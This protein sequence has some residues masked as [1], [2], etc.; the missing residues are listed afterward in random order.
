MWT[1][2]F[3]I[4]LT[5][6]SAQQPRPGPGQGQQGQQGQGQQQQQFNSPC[7]ASFD[8]VFRK[9]FIDSGNFQLDIIFSLI[10]NGTSGPLPQGTT[11]A[12]LLP[13]LCSIRTNVETCVNPLP[14]GIAQRQQCTDREQLMMNS[15]IQ[16]TSRAVASLCGVEPEMPACLGKFDARFKACMGQN[17]VNDDYFF[18]LLGNT[19]EGLQMTYDQLKNMTCVLQT[20]KTIVNCASTSLQ[21]LN[22]ECTQQEQY[23]VGQTLQNMMA[24]YQ[25]VCSG[26]PLMPRPPPPPECLMKFENDL[27][28][29]SRDS[30]TLGM[31][32][33]MM[34]LTQGTVPAGKDPNQM[35]GTICKNH[36][37]FEVCGKNA[38]KATTC[39][40]RNLLIAEGTFANIFITIGAYCHD[41]SMPGACMLTLQSQFAKCFG[42]V[43][44]DEASYVGNVTAHK[45]A[46][47][48]ST[49]QAAQTYC[50]KRKE[51]YVC[52]KKV[53]HRCPGAEQT[54][55]LTG[56]DLA[57]ME[58]AVNVL[59]SD[60]DE[61]LIGLK[62]FAKPTPKSV[63]CM[64]DMGDSITSLSQREMAR[65]LSL[66]N[67]FNTFCD[68]RVKH[69]E[70][71]T[72]AW[73]S[74][75]PKAVDLKRKFECHLIPTKC[76]QLNAKDVDK[77]CPVA[78]QV[79][80]HLCVDDMK[81]GIKNC[82]AKYN[83]DP[84][85]FLVNVTH[86]RSKM[87]GDPSNA[88]KLCRDK[89]EVYRCM[90]QT[91]DKCAGAVELLE[92]WG[93]QQD[94]VQNGIDL[95]CD[96]FDSYVAGFE[97]SSQSGPSV[98]SCISKSENSMTQLVSKHGG[99]ETSKD[100]GYFKQ[101]CAIKMEH[102]QCDLSAMKSKCSEGIMGLKTEFECTLIQDR[103]IGAERNS[104][105][106]VCNEN[107]YARAARKTVKP[108]IT[109]NS[110]DPNG[111][112][113]MSSVSYFTAVIVAFGSVVLSVL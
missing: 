49:K 11:R 52:M 26:R 38:I 95:L 22:G 83:I 1:I 113:A 3:I 14:A 79:K 57:S 25:G 100:A 82:I 68:I 32:D 111:A 71:D 112:S 51:L 42:E 7:L 91:L 17:Q 93:H 66:N 44:L 105:A 6:V 64:T 94:K 106:S 46:L 58:R 20:Q 24:S 10:T 69:V 33:M 65:G 73:T 15:T 77:I 31:G 19:T 41:T 99:M 54:M 86:D 23:M 74:C 62:C 75:D 101:F 8:Q 110:K 84:E 21:Q 89:A 88:R 43:G 28:K 102:L 108:G 36:K 12:S 45:G 5:S 87:I 76:H 104:V 16:S 30:T 2:I 50:G 109:G 48:G 55:A 56:F 9:C 107:N 59:C 37:D 27:D 4:G 34:L 39:K 67:F 97:C 47:L 96:N 53:M 81:E 80:P 72:S 60:I 61:Y 103:C 92:H 78:S 63:E 90:H 98:R 35:N 13:R 70:C 29:C 18:K 40:G 85:V